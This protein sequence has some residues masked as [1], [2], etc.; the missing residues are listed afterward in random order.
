MDTPE[1]KEPVDAFKTG[2]RSARNKSNEGQ[3]D[4]VTTHEVCEEFK[5]GK[6]YC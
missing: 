5:K 1:E 6:I 3:K 2:A 4:E